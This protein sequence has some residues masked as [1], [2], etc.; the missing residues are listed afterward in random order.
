MRAKPDM[1]PW[2]NR[3]HKIKS[4]VGAALLV[5]SNVIPQP[6]LTYGSAAL[7]GLKKCVSMPNPGLAPW[8][9]KKYRPYRAHC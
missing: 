8:A 3:G 4:S 1:E 2:V 9:L 5:P 6:N 7:A